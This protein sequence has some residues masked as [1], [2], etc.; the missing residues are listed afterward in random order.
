MLHQ[1]LTKTLQ[2]ID[3]PDL[4]VLQRHDANMEI[5]I[6]FQYLIQIFFLHFRPS[7]AHFALILWEQDLVDDDVVDVDL[8]LGQLLDQAFGLVH[9][10]ELRDADGNE[11]GFGAVFHLLVDYF[12]GLSHLFHLAEY[13]IQSL[14]HILFA[15]QD[16]AHVVQQFVEL[17]LEGQYLIEAFF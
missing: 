13:F 10:E 5:F 4:L 11:G 14:I 1:Q 3:S 6:Q 2:F 17:L 16:A 12:R 9:G 7:L 8:E 15:T